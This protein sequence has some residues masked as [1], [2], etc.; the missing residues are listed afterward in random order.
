MFLHLKFPGF[1]KEF[2]GKDALL[3]QNDK[4]L[5]KRFVQF[6]VDN[7]TLDTDPWPQGDEP[8]YKDGKVCGWTTSAAYGFTL[9][10]HVSHKIL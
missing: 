10:S 6:L 8:I 4:P 3:A 7:V 2:I 5:T 9:G 1:Q